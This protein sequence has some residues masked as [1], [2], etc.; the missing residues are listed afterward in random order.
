M[1][2]AL[3]ITL[4]HVGTN[5]SVPTAFPRNT[6]FDGR[7][8]LGAAAS[9]DGGA[10]GGSATHSHPNASNHLHLITF[11]ADGAGADATSGT[12]KL[13][14][15]A[16]THAA[17]NS[18]NT[19]VVFGAASNDP[20]YRE[21]IFVK[22]NG[23]S[24]VTNGLCAF[25][26]DAT[27]PTNWNELDGNGG[28]PDYRNKFLKGAATGADAGAS[29]GTLDAHSHNSD[30]VH[31]SVNSP[32][33]AGTVRAGGS[34]T[35]FANAHYH[36][37]SLLSASANVQNADGT[38]PY[39]KMMAIQNNTGGADTP[40]NLIG[41]WDLLLGDIPADW[42]EVT[43]QREKF[44]KTAS[45]SG[46]IGTTG[47]ADQHNHTCTAHNHIGAEA[48]PSSTA[49]IDD[50]PRD[51]NASSAGHVHG[52]TIGNATV[53]VANNTAKSNY[54]LYRT[55]IFIKYTKPPLSFFS[56]LPLLG[57]G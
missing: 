19:A 48:G 53:T 41:I 54:P 57:A 27:L 13:P 35:T 9:A 25:Y 28:R 42:A 21:V 34:A 20:P 15:Q 22:S 26:E 11:S 3:G 52:A 1:A 24:D 43:G 56:R 7:Y 32:I 38:P 55:A 5:A 36:E 51:V 49:D 4:F 16:H 44:L 12:I 31:A 46:E 10:T 37:T 23:T 47:G 40:N 33:S 6:D 29:G 8:V 45:G 17:F 2:V 14:K 18:A 50:Y 39:R 30:H